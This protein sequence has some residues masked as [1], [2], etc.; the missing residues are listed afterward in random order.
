MQNRIPRTTQR[1]IGRKSD[2]L[3]EESSGA[4]G[5]V[6]VGAAFSEAVGA[7]GSDGVD[8][9]EPVGT[10]VFFG[11]DGEGVTSGVGVTGFGVISGV[12]EATIS[13]TVK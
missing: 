3:C 6:G 12:G 9:A 10:A 2:P 8:A 5:D 4:E 13:V 11:S 1:M 7:A